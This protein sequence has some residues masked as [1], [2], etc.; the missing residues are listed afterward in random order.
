M[1]VYVYVCIYIYIY[2]DSY[3]I[4]CCVLYYIICYRARGRPT[5]PR[6]TPTAT[7]LY[8]DMLVMRCNGIY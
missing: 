6:P 3:I 8:H 5:G 1:C 4:L 2:I 7:M